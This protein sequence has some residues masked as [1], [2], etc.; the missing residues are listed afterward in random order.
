MTDFST[1]V[2]VRPSAG[3][4]RR[5][6]QTIQDEIGSLTVDV[7]PGGVDATGG[8]GGLSS[9]V[10]AGSLAGASD[11]LDE[12][13]QLASERNTLLG[14]IRDF[15][16]RAAMT[17]GDSGG[18][19][20]MM[21]S[22]LS[23]GALSALSGG[24]S[25]L[26]G[27]TSLGSLVTSVSLKS[28]ITRIPAF[29]TL[30]TAAD[31]GADLVTGK[32]TRDDIV[33]APVELGNMVTFGQLNSSAIKGAIGTVTLAIGTYQIGSI[34]AG[35]LGSSA[36][37][38]Y[39][40]STSIGGVLSGTLGS[41]ALAG[42]LGSTSIGGVLS[43]TLGSSALAG[44]LGSTSIGGVLSGTLG[45]SSLAGF[46]GSVGIGAILGGLGAGALAG[47]LGSV[48]ISEL[49]TGGS[50]TYFGS[51]PAE[52][53]NPSV[54]TGTA[55]P[56]NAPG[57]PG[58]PTPAGVSGSYN[59][60]LDGSTASEAITQYR[61]GTTTTNETSA[62]SSNSTNSTS[63]SRRSNRA[64][65]TSRQQPQITHKPTYNIDLSKLERKLDKDL[66]KLQQKVD[67][68]E[69]QIDSISSRGRR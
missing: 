4:L 29:A 39:L 67:D 38:G 5:T 53:E 21:G 34:I 18:G 50:V 40:G 22:V 8:G 52:G 15:S 69:S 6:E 42:Y 23:F 48:A 62:A 10:A 56:P 30:V 7:E 11:I 35:T 12:E 36:L 9:G 26:L 43:G 1:T 64:R 47:L 14:E 58:T 44:Y 41:S 37:A 49:I 57:S 32:L 65:E 63:S 55:R 25:S 61:N 28:L 68:L 24:L 19:G 13:V 16:E 17:G 60:D 66:R 27:K 46:L 59:P 45:S 51:G 33:S 2:D 3:S 20:G 31:L 54:P